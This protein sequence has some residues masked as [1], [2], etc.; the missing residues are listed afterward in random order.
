RR[1]WARGR[2]RDGGW[3]TRAGPRRVRGTTRTSACR[4]PRTRACRRASAHAIRV[5]SPSLWSL[6]APSYTM[7][8]RPGLRPGRLFA[9]DQGSSSPLTRPEDV[10]CRP[11]EG[12]WDDRMRPYEL[13]YL[14]QPTADEERLTAV[15]AQ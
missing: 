13:M 12:R 10:R 15:S 3:R 6:V 2:S 1:R 8:D 11:R 9:P 5:R 4:T 14:I 7:Q